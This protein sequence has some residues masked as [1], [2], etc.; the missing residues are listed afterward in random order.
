MKKE[1]KM[2]LPFKEIVLDGGAI[3][4][5]LLLGNNSKLYIEIEQDNIIPTITTL[6]ILEAEYILCRQLGKHVSIQKVDDLLASDYF[7]IIYFDT[8]RRKVSSLK[9]NNAIAIPDCATICAALEKNIPALF[10]KREKELD[11]VLENKS[12]EIPIYY[13][14]ELF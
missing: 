10:A 5:V 8:I 13:I 4:E 1:E 7:E 14:N 12:F 6:G 3:I 2:S 11:K 9:C